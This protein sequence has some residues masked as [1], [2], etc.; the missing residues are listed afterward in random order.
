MNILVYRYGLRAPHENRDLALSELRSS[1]EYR[2]KLIEIECAR[3]KRVRAAEDT[4]L[5]KPRL[6]LAEAQSALDAA[7]KAVS[8]HRAETRKRTTPA[9]MLATL[10]AAREAQHAASKA[11]RSARQLV[12]PRCSDCRKKDL[13]TPCEHATPEGVG[14]LA[15]LDAAQDEAKE[16]IKKFRNESGPFWGSYLLVDKAAGQSFSE[17]A[18]YDI[19]GKPN[20][21][22]FLRWTGE[23]TLGVQLQGGLSV[24]AALAGQDTQLRISSPPVACWDPST[25]SRKARSR[26][27]RESEVWLRQGSVGR[28]PIWCKFGLH[29]QR[30]LPPGAQIMW[31]EAHCRRVG[32]HFDWYLTLTLKVDDAVA[33]KPRIIPTR[34]AVA[35]DV[36]WRVFGEGETHELR[37]AYWSDGSNDAPVVIREKD[38]RVPGFVIPPRGELR[39]DTATLNQL[40]QPEGVRSER[41]VLFDG[42]RARL[43]EWLK[44][45]HENEPEW[46]DSDGV[47]VT[48]REHCKALHAWRS[49]AKMAALTSRWGEWLKEHPDGD[50]WAYD[51]LVAWRGQDRYL[52]AVESRWRDRARLRRRELYRLFGVALARTYGTVVLE[53]FDK[54]EIAK[55]PKTEDDGEAH[56]ARSNRQLA[57]VSELCECVAEAG[58]SRGRNVVEV[59]CENSTRECPVCGC[60]D[61]RNAARK[62][63]ISCACGHVWD[64]DDG[65]ADT[66]L[67]RWRKRPG[68]AKMAGAPRKPKILNGDG[69]VENRM[70]RAKRKGAEKALRKMELSKTTT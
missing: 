41:D 36:G 48:L 22:S 15:E 32:P 51:M 7:I 37:V 39:L 55:R 13:P 45:P 58:T 17:L 35:I 20:D 18:L 28:A 62:V 60:V 1:H 3:R 65:A 38:I 12:Q 42:V 8:K 50:K 59:P 66:L 19:D 11:F 34:D 25:G 6:K 14:L 64:Q 31:A 24:E 52:W 56:P 70:Q 68:D 43:I 69:S 44:T 29:M 21:P 5:G 54:R 63:T 27:S 10:K 46:V 2:N 30:P 16:A 4:L 33:L 61:E 67:G 53:E 9:E 57:A 47:V 23:G 40:T 49:Q 26:Q